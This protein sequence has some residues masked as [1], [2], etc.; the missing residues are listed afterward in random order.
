MSNLDPAEIDKFQSFANTWWDPQGPLH[1]LHE[2]NPLRLQYINEKVSGGLRGKRVLDVGCG[3]GIL[4]ESMAWQGAEV[5]GIDL[6]ED[7]IQAGKQHAVE[8][9]IEMQYR[10][11]AV[12][13]LAAAEPDSY[14]VVTCMEM[15][16]HVPD[17]A[18]IIASC[19]K[20]VKPG[21]SVFLSTL[22]RNPKSY[23]YAIVGAEYL[24]GLLPRGTHDYEKFLRPSELLD[25]IRASG[26]RLRDLQGMHYDPWRR[27][28]RL[29]GDVSVNYLCHC[30]KPA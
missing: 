12:E 14:D 10:A 2:I 21:G 5:L 28:A 19:A 3:A 29:T 27:V 25:M 13:D 4:S 8:R 18:S 9:G 30:Q 11:V 15:L 1:T 22:N 26:L 17:P 6:A 24:L 7:A 23:L 20:L 16:E